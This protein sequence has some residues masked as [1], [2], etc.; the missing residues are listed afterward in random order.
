MAT[1]NFQNFSLEHL[2]GFVG[3]TFNLNTMILEN[4]S[5]SFY[6]FVS[7][8]FPFIYIEVS[9]SFMKSEGKI[10]ISSVIQFIACS[11]CIV[12]DGD[13]VINHARSPT[14]CR[15]QLRQTVA[16]EV[17]KIGVPDWH[18]RIK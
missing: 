9:V 4:Q 7:I 15:T 18:P 16:G 14:D 2:M 12:I 17:A 5:T 6:Q 8:I 11:V 10:E 3:K 13:T 1:M